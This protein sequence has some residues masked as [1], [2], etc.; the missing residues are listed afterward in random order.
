MRC[1]AGA[2]VAALLLAGAV[3]GAAA[4]GRV[5]YGRVS[6]LVSDHQG[7]PLVGV[8][9]LIA[10]PG[11][12]RRVESVLTDAHGRF[13]AGDLLPGVYS[14]RLDRTGVIR[15]GVEVR[16]GRISELNL[17][18]SGVLPDLHPRPSQSVVRSGED[19]KW[20]LRTA[21]SVRPVLRYQQAALRER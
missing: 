15:T 21:A 2:V 13:S 3:A 1:A 20:I 4:P 6:G 17:I 5:T 9:V 10:G 14:L 8:T 19:W 7:N 12:T 11:V 18:L 16:P